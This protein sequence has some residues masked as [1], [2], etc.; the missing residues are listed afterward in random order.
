MRKIVLEISEST[1]DKMVALALTREKSFS[2]LIEHV[3]ENDS[4]AKEAYEY[5]VDLEYQQ[6]LERIV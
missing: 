3:L 1:Y 6:L 2:M 4:K 5:Q